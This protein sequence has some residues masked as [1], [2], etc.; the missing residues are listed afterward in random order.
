MRLSSQNNQFIFN[1][2]VDFIEPFLYDQFEILMDKNF[3]PYDTVLDYINSTIKEIT[4]PGMSINTVQQLRKYGKKYT[5]KEAMSIFDKFNPELE[6]SFRSVDSWLNYFMLLQLLAESYLNTKKV[7]IPLFSIQILDKDGTLVYTILLKELILKK[8][9]DIK[10]SYSAQDLSEETFSF[11]FQYNW[12]DIR[13]ELNEE[14]YTESKSI[15]NMPITFKPGKMDLEYN[16]NPL[17]N[18]EMII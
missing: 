1:F 5:Y 10:L 17:V 16:N 3:I 7:H 14:K 4:F 13:W 15:F 18:I 8:I 2:P 12:I 9:S 6:I 11:S